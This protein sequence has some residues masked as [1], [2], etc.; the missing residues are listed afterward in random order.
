MERM[1]VIKVTIHKLLTVLQFTRQLIS[2]ILNLSDL[3][4]R[5]QRHIFCHAISH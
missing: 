2:I 1:I 4:I 5:T 3:A